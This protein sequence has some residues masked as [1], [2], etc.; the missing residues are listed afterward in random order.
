M[1]LQ[2]LAEACGGRLL[3]EGTLSKQDCTSVVIDSRLVKEGSVFIAAAG[4]RV[5]GHRFIDACFT[6]GALGVVCERLPENPQGPCILVPDSL[7]ALREIAA[8]YRSGLDVLVVGITGSVG[9][10]STKEFVASVLSQKFRVHKTQGNYNNEIGLPLTVLQMTQETQIAVLEMG[11]SHFGEMHRLSEVAKPD[12]C[13]LTNIGQCHLEFLGSRQGILKAKT[14]IFDFIQEDGRV[15][16]NGDDDCLV[17]IGSVKGRAPIRFGLSEGDIYA[18]DVVSKGLFGSEA[19]IHTPEESFPVQ[20]PLPGEHMIYNAMA[21]TAAGLLFHMS[22]GEIA[23]GIAAVPAVDGRSHIIRLADKVIID[24]CYNANPVSM[25]SAI[26][27][28]ASADGR[29]VAV[30][31]DMFELGEEE[32]ALHAGIGE[33]AAKKGVDC[34]ICAG[35]L[36]RHMYEEAGIE[37]GNL[38]WFEDKEAV[39]RQIDTLLKPGDTVLIKASH[40]MGFEKLV[41]HLEGKEDSR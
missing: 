26:D 16:I 30:L 36:S 33:Y 35:A 29:K 27:L 14:E 9:K 10:T 15:I 37:A 17:T 25:R 12:V 4:E 21:A 5:D 28:L 22:S 41:R 23:A 6:Q 1:N 8:Y 7:T 40:G 39:L 11:I 13:I 2:E 24:D 18:T 34:L 19:V 38:H 3:Y 31:G 32:A 20:I